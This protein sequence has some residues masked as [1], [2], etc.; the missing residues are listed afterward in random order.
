MG[1]VVEIGLIEPVLTVPEIAGYLRTSE[2]KVRRLCDSGEIG[3]V[4]VGREYRVPLS[5]WRTYLAQI[6]FP[7][8]RAI[9]NAADISEA[10]ALSPA[11]AS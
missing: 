11:R 10:P 4:K 6:G 1:E 2:T 9:R 7:G 3:H 8:I 5:C